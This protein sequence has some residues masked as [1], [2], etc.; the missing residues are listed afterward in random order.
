M[1]SLALLMGAVLAAAAIAS[2]LGAGANA[3]DR[4]ER[5][6][7]TAHQFRTF[8]H[9]PSRVRAVRQ[10]WTRDR[11]RRAE[12]IT[13]ERQARA[14]SAR[15]ENG[16][17]TRRRHAIVIRGKPPAPGRDHR[18]HIPYNEHELSD[19]ASFPNITHGKVF[20]VDKRRRG[21]VECSATV[22][23]T[24]NRSVVFTAAHCVESGGGR[25]NW[26][27]RW[28]F[29]PG[30]RH[31]TRPAGTF[32]AEQTWITKGWA[33]HGKRSND[34]IGAAV[35]ATNG[36]GERVADAVGARGFATYEGRNQ[37]F[38]AFGYPVGP[39]F[40]GERLWVCESPYGGN[41]PGSYRHPG[42]PTM[43]IGCDLTGGA[44]G[45]GWII[46]DE[47]LNSVISYSYD[48]EPTHLYGPYFGKGA[49]RLFNKVRYR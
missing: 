1:A 15:P 14:R 13:V 48:N 37:F 42:P 40:D 7:D 9:S 11:M 39:P 44:S 19:T 26:Y 16:A 32:V 28:Q 33:R 24:E 20:A 35:L 22:V 8:P 10:F 36:A 4:S 17:S 38:R 45:G 18:S 27:R 25:F 43:A 31:G 41:D 23:N 49:G 6:S 46:S 47:F 29:V 21:L 12:P 30:Y 34:D 3:A 5:A 2:A